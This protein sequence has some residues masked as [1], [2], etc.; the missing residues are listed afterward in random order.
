MDGTIPGI[1]ALGT[2]AITPGMI[3][4]IILTA[5]MAIMAGVGHTTMA[6]TVGVIPTITVIHITM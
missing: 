6:T 3:L 1:T 4:G 2:A 5:I